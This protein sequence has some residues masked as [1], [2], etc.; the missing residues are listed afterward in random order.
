ML[1]E[2]EINGRGV[3]VARQYSVPS[4]NEELLSPDPAE[5]HSS[6]GEE[7]R[8]AERDVIVAG[9]RGGCRELPVVAIIF[10]IH[11]RWRCGYGIR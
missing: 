11:L 7:G 1:G 8:L 5:N 4:F 9:R 2:G 10:G 6:S 3:R